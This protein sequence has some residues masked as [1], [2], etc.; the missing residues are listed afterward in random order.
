VR[1]LLGAGRVAEAALLLGRAPEI[2]GVVVRGAGRGRAFG[3]PTANIAPEV[4][5]GVGTGIYA[6]RA[7]L[8]DAAGVTFAA[9]ISVGTNPT[10]AQPGAAGA[11]PVTIEAYLLDYPGEDL[12]GSNMRLS[13]VQH[14]RDERRFESVAA[15]RA[16]IDRDI[17][18]TREIIGTTG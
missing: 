14:L 13:F 3:I 8:L 1:E 2:T 6:G 9:A 11:S 18:R 5:L 10:F 4:P 15:L 17:A 7:V 12:Y 16:E